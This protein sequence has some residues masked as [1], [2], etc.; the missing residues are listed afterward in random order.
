MSKWIK[1]SEQLPKIDYSLPLYDRRI[2]VI[3][4]SKDGWVCELTYSHNPAKGD[5]PRWEQ[6]GDVHNTPEYWMPLPEPPKMEVQ[7]D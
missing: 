4:C 7:D 5:Y 2:R 1:T 3:G 6:Y